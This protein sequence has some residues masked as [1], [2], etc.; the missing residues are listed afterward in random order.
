MSNRT[1]FAERQWQAQSPRPDKHQPSP[2]EY[3]GK[4]RRIEEFLAY[5]MLDLERLILPFSVSAPIIRA[6]GDLQSALESI[7]AQQSE[8]ADDAD[9]G[10]SN[11]CCTFCVCP[12]LTKNGVV[13]G[14]CQRA[15][16]QG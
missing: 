7:Q 12:V 11:C 3:G 8:S 5:E 13:C 2:L 14:D 4:R 1:Y 10:R 16:H 9:I 6:I 15:A